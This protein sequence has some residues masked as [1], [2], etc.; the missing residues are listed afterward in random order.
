MTTHRHITG[1]DLIQYAPTR[2]ILTK[3]ERAFIQKL[4]DPGRCHDRGQEPPKEVSSER[5]DRN[6]PRAK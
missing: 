1:A 2:P 6:T 5:R 3:E 4:N